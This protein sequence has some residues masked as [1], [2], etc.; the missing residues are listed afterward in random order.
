MTRSVLNPRARRTTTTLM[1]R[2]FRRY[3]AFIA[4]ALAIGGAVGLTATAQR[5]TATARAH[6]LADAQRLEDTTL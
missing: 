1:S 5:A 4:A 6:R 2:T 3:L